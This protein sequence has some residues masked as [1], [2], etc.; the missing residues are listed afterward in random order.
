MSFDYLFKHCQSNY[1]FKSLMKGYIVKKMLPEL[2]KRLFD[3]N[4][5]E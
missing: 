5:T 1:E 4:E 2:R 3:D